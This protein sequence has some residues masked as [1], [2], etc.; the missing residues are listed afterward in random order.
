MFNVIPDLAVFGK[1][2]GGGL[3]IGAIGC[4]KEILDSVLDLDPPLS[5]AGTFNGN[6]MTIASAN[7]RLTT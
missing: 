3:P 2:L 4:P 6:A 1:A 7:A 5:V